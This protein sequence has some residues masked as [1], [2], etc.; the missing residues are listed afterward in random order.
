MMIARHIILVSSY[1]GL[2]AKGLVSST[3]VAAVDRCG[4]GL[5]IDQ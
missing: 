2:K 1:S 5:E 3:G 4:L